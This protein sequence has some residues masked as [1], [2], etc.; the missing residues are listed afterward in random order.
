MASPTERR[1]FRTEHL[2]PQA[3]CALTLLIDCSGSMKQHVNN[4]ALLADVLAR[5]LE[6]VGVAVEVLGYT[7]ATWNGGRVSKAWQSAGRPPHP[8]RL[9]ELRHLV[10][11]DAGTSWR[12]SRLGLAALQKPDLYREGVDGEAV[13]WACTRLRAQDTTLCGHEIDRRLLLVLSDGSPMDTATHLA[14]DVHYLDHHLRQ[15]VERQEAQGGVEILGLGVG[16]DLSPFYSRCQALDPA[17][18]ISHATLGE[19]MELMSGRRHR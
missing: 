5:T 14:N 3:R 6:Q 19:V 1:L 2:E 11:K 15:V 4:T 16:L 13:D 18:T 10:F 12:R 7:T 8:G 9:N 17:A